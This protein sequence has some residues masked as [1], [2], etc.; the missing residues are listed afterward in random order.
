MKLTI[1]ID[2][3]ALRNAVHAQVAQAVSALAATELQQQ[4]EDI[5]NKKFE[6]FDITN[7]VRNQVNQLLGKSIEDLISAALGSGGNKYEKVRQIVTA[8]TRKIIKDAM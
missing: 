1:E 4:A 5:I 7:I 2:D 6:R 3:A 8:E